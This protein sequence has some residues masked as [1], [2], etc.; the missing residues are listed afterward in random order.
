MN[1]MKS[2]MKLNTID[3]LFAVSN[4]DQGANREK[5]REISLSSLHSFAH[6]PFQ[7]RDDVD[8]QELV[9]SIREQ[10]VL[11]PVIV[12]PMP[13]DRGEGYELI[14]GHRR[15]HACELLGLGTIP[16]MVQDL[17]DDAATIVMVDSNLQREELLPSEKAFAYKL[18]L[19]AMK[20]QAGRPT[21]ENCSQL[22]NNLGKRSSEM[23]A[24]QAGQ[25]KN[26]IFRFIRLTELLPELLDMV[27]EKK[28]AF[29]PA[30]ELSFLSHE[31]QAVI[32]EALNS[33]GG[34]ISLAQ[35]E[36][37]KKLSQD[38]QFTRDAALTILC[39]KPEPPVRITIK[40]KKIRQYFPESYSQKQMEEVIFSLLEKW[41]AQNDG[42]GIE[43]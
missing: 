4:S 34:S 15:K 17:D 6:H 1:S 37:L 12:R 26:Q 18:K 27:D 7:V 10:G 38:G 21:K 41:K 3:D 40:E 13:A 30:Y 31:E 2:K 14:A 28:I 33:E 42:S 23:L 5:I 20:R 39:S 22:G 11:V 8:M 36:Q 16:A 43:E 19:E 35:A 32:L 9:D 25:S 24:E 29:N